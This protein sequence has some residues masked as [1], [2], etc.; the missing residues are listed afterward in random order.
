MRGQELRERD[1]P[2]RP[3]RRREQVVAGLDHRPVHA[4]Q[5]GPD[6]Q[7]DEADVEQGDR[8]HDGVVAEPDLRAPVACVTIP[9]RPIVL[10]KN[11]S[12]ARA[13]TSSGTMTLM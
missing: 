8:A 7:Q 13:M 11:T 1:L 5:P 9:S 10:A 6:E 2:E 3:P 12:V 4:R